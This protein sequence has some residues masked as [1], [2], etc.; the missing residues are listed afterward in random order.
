MPCFK[1]ESY[2]F[3]E[4]SADENRAVAPALVM[5]IA[6]S[7]CYRPDLVHQSTAD[8]KDPVAQRRRDRALKA[9]DQ[10]LNQMKI[11]LVCFLHRSQ[12]CW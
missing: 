7:K 9:L 5:L 6:L 3:V 2:F 1:D 8:I 11:K 4:D 12:L 10:K